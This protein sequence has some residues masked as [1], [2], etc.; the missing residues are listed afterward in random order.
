MKGLRSLKTDPDGK[1]TLATFPRL[2]GAFTG[3][4]ASEI[5]VADLKRFRAEG[6]AEGLSD[7]RLNRYMATIRAIFN[8][9]IK[10]ELITRA[11]APSY[12]PTVAEPNEARGAVFVEDGWY[13]PLNKAAS[14]SRCAQPSCW[15][16]TAAYGSTRCFACGGSTSIRRLDS[17]RCPQR[18]PRRASH[19]WCPGIRTSN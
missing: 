9:A 8:R 11:E 15:P 5:T 4:R 3:W 14:R 17:P 2:D 7:V 12:F 19:A 13:A 18:S 6:K 1:T 16:T 10:D